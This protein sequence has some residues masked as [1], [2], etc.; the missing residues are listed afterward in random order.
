MNWKILFK[1]M[2]FSLLPTL[3]TF[4]LLFLGFMSFTQAFNFLTANGDLSIFVRIS[5]FIAEMAL[6]S[7]MYRLYEIEYL[8]EEKIVKNSQEL[9][10]KI[11]LDSVKKMSDYQEV[12]R[13]F[14][15]E[16]GYV[17]IYKTDNENYIVLKKN[18]Y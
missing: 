11:Q 9:P 14:P 12:K 16:T 7:Y 6:I 8:Q 1:A 18:V 4:T 10:G 5:L 17:N 2:K 15:S 13:F 3:L